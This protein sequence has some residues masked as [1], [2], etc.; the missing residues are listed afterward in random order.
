[1]REILHWNDIWYTGGL[2]HFLNCWFHHKIFEMDTSDFFYPA[3]MENCIFFQQE[4]ELLRQRGMRID[5]WPILSHL[6]V[7]ITLSESPILGHKEIPFIIS[8]NL[9]FKSI[10]GYKT[11]KFLSSQN[12]IDVFLQGIWVFDIIMTLWI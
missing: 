7:V 4:S 6:V 8:T 12:Y 3:W 2:E 9:H 11:S 1:M 10:I 5:Q